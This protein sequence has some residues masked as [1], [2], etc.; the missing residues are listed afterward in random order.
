MVDIRAANEP[1]IEVLRDAGLQAGPAATLVV[2][3]GGRI[4]RLDWTGEHPGPGEHPDTA[5][6]AGNE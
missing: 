5:P 6:G 3:A 4:V 2:D 1:L